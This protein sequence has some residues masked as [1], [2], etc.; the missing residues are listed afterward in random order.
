MIPRRKPNQSFPKSANTSKLFYIKQSNNTIMIVA[1]LSMIP[2]GSGTSASE[3]VRAVHEVLRD[4]GVNF[5]TG[6]MS[7]S[8]ETETMEKLFQ[9]VEKANNRLA[10]MGVQRIV[11]MVRIDF[12]LDKEVSMDTKLKACKAD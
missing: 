12:R 5:V 10:A 9:I 6:P 2:M 4:S 7:T 11:T 8:I 3:Y 1:D